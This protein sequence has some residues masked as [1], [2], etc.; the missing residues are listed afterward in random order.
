MNLFWS[1]AGFLGGIFVFLL[2]VGLLVLLARLLFWG[3]WRTHHRSSWRYRNEALDILD[4]RYAKGE[5]TKEQ[6][7]EMKK[8]L[9]ER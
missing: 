3:T 9:Q 8:T 1:V 7:L 2:F 4:A 6:Y 5:I